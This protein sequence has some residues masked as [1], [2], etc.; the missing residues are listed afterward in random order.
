MAQLNHGVASYN[1]VFIRET[2]YKTVSVMSTCAA[3]V[4]YFFLGHITPV[5]EDLH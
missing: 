5:L 2:K 4:A 3:Q 1:V